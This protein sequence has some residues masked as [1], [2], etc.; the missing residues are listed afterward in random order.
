MTR[1]DDMVALRYDTLNLNALPWILAGHAIEIL[2]ER[3][4]AVS[5][6]RIVLC[7]LGARVLLDG[8]RGPALVEHQLVER[9]RGALVVFGRARRD[10]RSEAVVDGPSAQAILKISCTPSSALNV[11]RK[12]LPPLR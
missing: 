12:P 3:G 1:K 7:A 4:F 6:L 9:D 10:V 8:Q 11:F 2:D 5:D